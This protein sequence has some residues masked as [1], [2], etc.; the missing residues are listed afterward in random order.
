M[1]GQDRRAA[2]F[3]PNVRSVLEIGRSV[4]GRQ[5]ALPFQNTHRTAS[6]WRV[7]P[8]RRRR[9]RLPVLLLAHSLH[10]IALPLRLVPLGLPRSRRKWV[11]YWI[12]LPPSALT[13]RY[14]DGQSVPQSGDWKHVWRA[15]SGAIVRLLASLALRA[16]G[17]ETR[18]SQRWS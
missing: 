17:C 10:M 14:L 18:R 4:T 16:S 6:F 7:E 13:E 15:A 2:N 1:S 12:L 9:R 11:M 8:S 3:N 5:P